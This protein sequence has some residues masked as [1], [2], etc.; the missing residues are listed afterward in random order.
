MSHTG[1]KR[2]SARS[3]KKIACRTGKKSRVYLRTAFSDN[4]VAETDKKINRIL[5]FLEKIPKNSCKTGIKP[6]KS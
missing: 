5:K 2:K 6:M 1:K 4:I 3:T